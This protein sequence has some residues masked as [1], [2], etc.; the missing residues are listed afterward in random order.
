MGV[1]INPKNQ[2]KEDWL[3]ENCISV[4][5]YTPVFDQTKEIL[6][7]CLV[8]N[9]IFTAAGIA[10]SEREREAFLDPTDRREKLWFEVKTSKLLE[11]EPSLKFELE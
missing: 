11:V 9:G 3:R 1:Y 5:R 2:S 10:F 6:P 4:S 8:D 7:V